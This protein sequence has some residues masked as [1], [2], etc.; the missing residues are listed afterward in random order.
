MKKQLFSL[1]FSMYWKGKIP[2]SVAVDTGVILIIAIVAGCAVDRSGTGSPSRT[3]ARLFSFSKFQAKPAC[4]GL[5]FK[6]CPSGTTATAFKNCSED[7][8]AIATQMIFSAPTIHWCLQP[9]YF[10]SIW[11]FYLRFSLSFFFFKPDFSLAFDI[12]FTD[13]TLNVALHV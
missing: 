1:G 3:C 6:S 5:S 9:I 13:M 8:I 7:T 4:G 11:K 2:V 10:H 12:H